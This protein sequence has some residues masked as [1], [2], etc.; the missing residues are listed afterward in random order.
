MLDRT[1]Q[2][3]QAF[4]PTLDQAYHSEFGHYN[5][6]HASNFIEFPASVYARGGTS[7]SDCAVSLK[8]TAR[9]FIVHLLYEIHP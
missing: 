9:E 2:A 7:S 1:Y 4:L 6:R 3:H 8:A 5:L